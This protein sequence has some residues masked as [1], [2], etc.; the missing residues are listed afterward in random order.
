MAKKYEIK[1]D[2]NGSM[3]SGSTIVVILA[4]VIMLV[5]I[6]NFINP[7]GKISEGI[8]DALDDIKDGIGDAL[9][10]I[11]EKVGLG[12]DKEEDL[13]E[14]TLVQ[15]P[16]L[17]RREKK[18]IIVERNYLDIIF[19]MEEED[20]VYFTSNESKRIF[21][22]YK[23]INYPHGKV[24]YTNSDNDTVR[25]FYIHPA[26]EGVLAYYIFPD[27]FTEGMR[28]KTFFSLTQ[29]YRA[30]TSTYKISFDKGHD[31]RFGCGTLILEIIEV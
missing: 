6:V 9:D 29:V 25:R 5:L 24:S 7:L 22:V 11:K 18:E 1:A 20:K 2:N 4:L 13:K 8:G 17:F 21:E 10:D 19:D 30:D 12:I 16:S 15:E 26:D 31:A 28:C 23:Y 14:T 3:G 27:Y